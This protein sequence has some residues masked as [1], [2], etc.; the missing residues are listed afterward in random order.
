M[1]FYSI[2]MYRALKLSIVLLCLLFVKPATADD[3]ELREEFDSLLQE[4]LILMDQM[5]T[6]R[7]GEQA[8]ALATKYLE[9]ANKQGALAPRID[10]SSRRLLLMSQV[11]NYKVAAIMF[12]RAGK[13]Y[14]EEGRVEKAKEVY[15]TIIQLF[16]GST[17]A[18]ERDEG[19]KELEAL[20]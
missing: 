13:L 7:T 17:F 6:V 11:D 12:L 19:S 1:N 16:I 14:T 2:R 5:K 3:K 9:L 15:R 4:T 20:E 10:S 18:E 8:V